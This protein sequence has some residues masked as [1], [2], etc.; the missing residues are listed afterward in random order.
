MKKSFSHVCE[1]VFD[2]DNT[3]YP[4]HCDLFVQM[5]KRITDYVM[6]VTG[7]EYDEAYKEQKLYYREHGTTLRGLM[8][9][10][11]IDPHDY[12]NDVHD[13]D[14]S[15]VAPNPQLGKLIKALPG[16]KHIFTNG[17][18]PHVERTLAALQIEDVFDEVFDITHAE[19]EPKPEPGP[20]DK[21]LRSH[22]I[23]PTRAAMFEDMARNLEVPKALGMATVLLVPQ[24]DEVS[25]R[26]A[27]EHHGRDADHI[28]HVSDD[29]NGFISRI[30]AVL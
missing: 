6:R 12:L 10:H 23:D 17:D 24:A 1:W 25:S 20:Y 30:I 3:L 28:D 26:Q 16:R 14:Y 9:V 4:S 11:G 15:P 19:F 18:V 5:D 7:K 22:K 29:L 21:F 27:W 2:L 13:I 8:N